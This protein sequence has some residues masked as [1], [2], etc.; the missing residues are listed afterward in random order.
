MT[1]IK[2]EN[3]SA[4]LLKYVPAYFRRGHTFLSCVYFCAAGIC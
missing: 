2:C 4:V 3:K 1:P